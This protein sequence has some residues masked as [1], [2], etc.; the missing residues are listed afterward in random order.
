MKIKITLLTI[1]GTLSSFAAQPMLGHIAACLPNSQTLGGQDQALACRYHYGIT[2]GFGATE[3]H[4]YI[5]FDLGPDISSAAGI[6]STS[7]PSLMVA[8]GGIPTTISFKRPWTQDN[9]AQLQ[10]GM[11]QNLP[12]MTIHNLTNIG[13]VKNLLPCIPGCGGCQP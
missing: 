12:N 5:R 1:I 9:V 13:G 4:C 11:L 8:P 3:T 2:N 6:T 10:R 7:S